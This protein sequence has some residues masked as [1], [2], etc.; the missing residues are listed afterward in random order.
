[1]TVY[2]W[3]VVLL[4]L[5]ALLLRGNV[6]GN[7]KFIIVA[8]FMLFFVM[9]FRDAYSVGNDSASSYL[10]LFQQMEDTGWSEITGR[11]EDN[12]NIVFSYLMKAMY[13]LTDGNY[14]MFIVVLSAFEIIVFGKFIMKYSKSPIQSII[15]YLGL[16]FYIFNF[17]ALKQGL[18]MTFLLLAFSAIIDRKPV[19]FVLLTLAGSMFH[20]PA[21]V[22]LPAYWIARIKMGRSFVFLL[23]AIVVAVLAF[24]DQILN[25]MVGFY[26]V[27]E[28]YVFEDDGRYITGKVTVMAILVVGAFFLRKPGANEAVYR[29]ALQIVSVSVVIQLFSVYNNVFERLA[30][31][32]FQFSVVLV[33]FVFERSAEERKSGN[34]SLITLAKSIGPYVLGVLC[35]MRFFDYVSRPTAYLLPYSF[36]FFK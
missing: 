26:D 6:K 10:H 9:G 32:Y 29:A 15:Y 7:K 23:I 3:L 25:Y 22:F 1:M 11:G 36:C 13:M 24:R 5:A 16:W 28:S 18:A 30:D 8:C 34:Q 31:Y 14:Q 19:K 33:P 35:I 21:I 20:F 12:R 4:L 17:N 2:T 27:Y